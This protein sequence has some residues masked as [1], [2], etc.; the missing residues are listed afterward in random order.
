M[1]RSDDR[2]DSWR[3]ISG[4]LSRNLDRLGLPMMGRVWSIDAVWDLWAMSK[5][6]TITSLAQSPLDEKLIYAGTDDGLIQVTED[7][8]ATWRLGGTV[9]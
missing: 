6:S 3:P 4:D 2:G 9:R 5:F 1:W 7:G 8:G